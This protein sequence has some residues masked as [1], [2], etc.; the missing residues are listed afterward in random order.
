MLPLYPT[1][2]TPRNDTSKVLLL[3]HDRHREILCRS[4]G[5]AHA[6][7]LNQ[8]QTEWDSSKL[9]MPTCIPWFTDSIE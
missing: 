2:A 1:G 4:F 9:L 3:M 5:V 6:I 8:L 7:I